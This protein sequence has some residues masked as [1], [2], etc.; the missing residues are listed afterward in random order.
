MEQLTSADRCDRCGVQAYVRVSNANL[1]LDF[2]GHDYAK[3]GEALD[4]EGW[5]ISIDTRELLTRRSVEVG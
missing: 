1:T 2:C 3:L 4:A 5:G